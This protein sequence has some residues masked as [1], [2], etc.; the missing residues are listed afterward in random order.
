M[1]FPHDGKITAISGSRSTLGENELGIEIRPDGRPRGAVS[2]NAEGGIWSPAI[3][4]SLRDKGMTRARIGVGNLVG[5]YRN[6]EG[7]VSYTTLDRV[8]KALPQAQF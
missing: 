4:E 2:G 8:M 7:G 3:I 5:V 1:V 6:E